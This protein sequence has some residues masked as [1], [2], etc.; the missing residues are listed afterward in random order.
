[1]AEPNLNK[2]RVHELR[3]LLESRAIKLPEKRLLRK[4]LIALYKKSKLKEEDRPPIIADLIGVISLHL[5]VHII[6]RLGMM[7]SQYRKLFMDRWFWERKYDSDMPGRIHHDTIPNWFLYYARFSSRPVGYLYYITSHG[8]PIKVIHNRKEL[9]IRDLQFPKYN[10]DT[11]CV[12]TE[13]GTIMEFRYKF[14]SQDLKFIREYK[15]SHRARTI[16]SNMETP[17]DSSYITI[18]NELVHN[19]KIVDVGVKSIVN[20]LP[21]FNNNTIYYLKINGEC[22]KY[23]SISKMKK[24]LPE[25]TKELI[26]ENVVDYGHNHFYLKDWNVLVMAGLFTVP[27]EKDSLRYDRSLIQNNNMKL[28]KYGNLLANEIK[29]NLPIPIY[30]FVRWG[31]SRFELY[32]IDGNVYR[33]DEGTKT[34]KIVDS[35]FRLI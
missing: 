12:V 35:G 26:L 29:I 8:P 33:T 1:M 7:N 10:N 21:F 30:D 11:M 9:K 18:D 24:L 5:P 3:A 2:L 17:E 32:G 16:P 20:I 13:K 31:V 23:G 34:M 25:N 19:G 6:Y 4:D 22:I 28:D 14:N 15:L 27:R